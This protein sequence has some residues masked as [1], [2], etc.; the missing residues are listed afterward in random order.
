MQAPNPVCSGS[1]VSGV[2]AHT[3]IWLLSVKWMACTWKESTMFL[4]ALFPPFC[5]HKSRTVDDEAI[6]GL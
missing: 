5:E 4:P 2:H 6:F 3:H 1:H